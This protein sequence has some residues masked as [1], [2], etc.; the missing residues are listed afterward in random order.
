MTEALTASGAEHFAFAAAMLCFA[1]YQHTLPFYNFD[2]PP[3]AFVMAI[4]FGLMLY[5]AYLI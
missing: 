2:S 3:E 5:S 1:A 4:S